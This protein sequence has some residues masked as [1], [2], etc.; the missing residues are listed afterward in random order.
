MD[1]YLKGLNII[2]LLSLKHR[3]LRKEVMKAWLKKNGNEVSDTESHM[4]GMLEI[5][6]M[7]VAEVAR[8]MNI[9]RQ[10]AHKSA[11]K[12]IEQNYI[13]M[14]PI[15]GNKR[16]K[17]IVLTKKG[18]E[19]STEMLKIKRRIEEEISENIGNETVEMFKNYL[20][21]DWISSHSK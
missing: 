15:E 5:K 16:D 21:K 20:M 18:E 11:K 2:D 3:K 7:T 13:K 17:L 12:L 9:T 8:K 6:G 14:I 4:L 10:S 19:Y 1:E